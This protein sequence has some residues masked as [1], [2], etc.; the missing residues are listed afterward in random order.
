MEGKWEHFGVL[1]EA[2]TC[3]PR[4]GGTFVELVP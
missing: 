3:T 2:K 1:A 4:G